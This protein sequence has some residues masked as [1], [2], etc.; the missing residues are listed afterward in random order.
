MEW[1]Q[2]NLY[3]FS[4]IVGLVIGVVYRVM[5]R[6]NNRARNIDNKSSL[7]A[8]CNK[9]YDNNYYTVRSLNYCSS[10]FERMFYD[11]KLGGGFVGVLTI[12]A[13]AIMISFF[14]SKLAHGNV[15][16]DDYWR[17]ASKLV[18]LGLLLVWLIRSYRNLIKAKEEHHTRSSSSSKA[19]IR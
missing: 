3:L 12:G 18:V 11:V 4:I 2:N 16:S 1:I 13:I 17:F 5:L 8:K 10:C 19:V 9:K 6:K 15:I 14:M 7:C